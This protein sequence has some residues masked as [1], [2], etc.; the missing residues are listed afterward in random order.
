MR[1]GGCIFLSARYRIPRSDLRNDEKRSIFEVD[2]DGGVIL[3]AKRWMEKH[4]EN[5]NNDIVIK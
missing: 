4:G 2:D 3:V 1:E 5:K